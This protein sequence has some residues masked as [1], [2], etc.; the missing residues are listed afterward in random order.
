[1]TPQQIAT[2]LCKIEKLKE[3]V[4]VAQMTEI[5]ATAMKIFKRRQDG[6]N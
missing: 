4:N 3:Q 5:V 6:N 1:M 2:D